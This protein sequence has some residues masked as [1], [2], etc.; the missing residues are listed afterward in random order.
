MGSMMSRYVVSDSTHTVLPERFRCRL[1]RQAGGDARPTDQFFVH[2]IALV[3]PNPMIDAPAAFGHLAVMSITANSR[4]GLHG[5]LLM[6]GDDAACRDAAASS[7]RLSAPPSS[8][9][10]N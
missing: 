4:P 7:V 1:R 10:P 5:A 9:R 8:T 3:L 2:P 6:R